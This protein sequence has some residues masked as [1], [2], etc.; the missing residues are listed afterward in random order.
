MG[1]MR[2]ANLAAT[3]AVRSAGGTMHRE[4][5]RRRARPSVATIHVENLR[6]RTFVGFNSEERSKQQDVVINIEIRHRVNG[7]VFDDEV[8]QALNYK[9]IT[10]EVID[11]VE[12]SRFLLLEKLAADILDI[13]CT[14][15]SVYY[16]KVRADKPHALRFAD[17][18]SI[19]LEFCEEANNNRKRNMS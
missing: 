8:S 18:V 17:S 12:N 5:H 19:T 13:C 15:S 2:F 10:K 7:A 14:A 1:D 3:D 6:L 11:C 16:A 4:T 9:S